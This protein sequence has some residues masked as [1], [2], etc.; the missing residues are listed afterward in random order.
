MLSLFGQAG[1]RLSL[2]CL[3]RNAW[4]PP[5]DNSHLSRDYHNSNTQILPQI[6]QHNTPVLQVPVLSDVRV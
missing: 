5:V 3:A 1:R 2:L 6:C 4:H